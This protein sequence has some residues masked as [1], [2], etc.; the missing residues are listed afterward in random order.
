MSTV[1]P[2]MFLRLEKRVTELEVKLALLN[3]PAPP[4]H[5]VK[6]IETK[7]RAEKR[8]SSEAEPDKRRR[9]IPSSIYTIFTDGS[10]VANGKPDCMAGCGVYVK[11]IEFR[12]QGKPDG[13][14]SSNRGELQ[15][16]IVAAALARHV[17]R[18]VVWTDSEY[19]FL[20]ITEKTR[21]EHWA[22]NSWKKKSGG[23]AANIDLWKAMW[24]LLRRREADGLAPI[25][26]RWTRSHNG[27]STQDPEV[28][29]G[30]SIADQLAGAGRYKPSPWPEAAGK[31]LKELIARFSAA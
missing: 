12:W 4:V 25:E 14:Q 15:A 1:T 6:L 31:P 7:P 27:D 17:P 13:D 8:S 20:G 2:E 29:R 24:V 22:L 3:V 5:A 28:N 9:I 26:W 19:M 10:A 18:V 21:L 23:T 16:G 30:N 11:E